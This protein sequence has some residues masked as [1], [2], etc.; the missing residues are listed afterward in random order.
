MSDKVIGYAKDNKAYTKDD[1]FLGMIDQFGNVFD[2]T[3]TELRNSAIRGYAMPLGKY[4]E[5]LHS[6]ANK[7]TLAKAI[8]A[9]PLS[10]KVG[11]DVA[12]QF[13]YLQ[14]K[15]N[16]VK[17]AKQRWILQNMDRLQLDHYPAGVRDA[18]YIRIAK[19]DEPTDEVMS[20]YKTA[21]SKE[22]LMK[23]TPEIKAMYSQEESLE[24]DVL[25][26][27]AN[28]YTVNNDYRVMKNKLQDMD[29][30]VLFMKGTIKALPK[31]KYG[32]A[33]KFVKLQ[34]VLKN[35]NENLKIVPFD[36][37]DEELKNA[38]INADNYVIL[39]DNEGR[40]KTIGY[41]PQQ[42]LSNYIANG[43]NLDPRVAF[44]FTDDTHNQMVPAGQVLGDNNVPMFKITSVDP[45]TGVRL[46]KKMGY[47]PEKPI[48]KSQMF[49]LL[50]RD[51]N[52]L[53]ELTA[54]IDTR[55]DINADKSR[56]VINKNDKQAE[57]VDLNDNEIMQVLALMVQKEGEDSKYSKIYKDFVDTKEPNRDVAKALRAYDPDFAQSIAYRN[58]AIK[59]HL[60]YLDMD[61]KPHQYKKSPLNKLLGK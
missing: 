40:A 22:P 13:G 49:E 18:I 15:A 46:T 19:E 55:A 61:Q 23:V 39:Y 17:T 36:N 42:K 3:K 59:I 12:T 11:D 27:D 54:D 8:K 4:I 35:P 9:D 38:S 56:D 21:Y 16:E 43:N 31:D 7:E 32:E 37:N 57:W 25:T 58:G 14:G 29:I 53:A 51:S 34:G 2:P 60:P 47:T 1:K 30:P 41:A 20:D 44:K 10:Q 6:D 24:E 50:S 26:E 5:L 28:Y 33:P 45:E 48:S 52:T